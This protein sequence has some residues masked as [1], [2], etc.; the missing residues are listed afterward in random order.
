MA[1]SVVF[2]ACV[3]LRISDASFKENQLRRRLLKSATINENWGAIYVLTVK[4]KK[5]WAQ[6]YYQEKWLK[7]LQGKLRFYRWAYFSNKVKKLLQE[8]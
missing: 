6:P 7:K 4:K 3:P 5:E 2:S 8:D 1:K